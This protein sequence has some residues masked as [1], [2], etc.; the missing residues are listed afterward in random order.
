LTFTLDF[1]SNDRITAA[2]WKASPV[3]KP[4]ASGPYAVILLKKRD[5]MEN[6]TT[7]F[8]DNETLLLVVLLLLIYTRKVSR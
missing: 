3:I 1:G 6:L 2:S 8:N 7:W 4:K 5:Y